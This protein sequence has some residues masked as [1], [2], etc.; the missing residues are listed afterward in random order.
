MASRGEAQKVAGSD[1][2]EI[3]RRKWIDQH[4]T[5]TAVF[6]VP[7]SLVL[8]HWGYRLHMITSLVPRPWLL[9]IPRPSVIIRIE[10]LAWLPVGI[11][12]R[13]IFYREEG[14]ESSE[15]QK[16]FKSSFQL[17]NTDISCRIMN[18]IGWREGHCLIVHSCVVT[19]MITL[20]IISK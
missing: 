7:F 11:F 8:V 15:L 14:E 12:Y 13:L 10:M 17:A 9:L 18:Y 16:D 3:R 1:S 20:F 4:K 5:A 2:P 19:V 6:F